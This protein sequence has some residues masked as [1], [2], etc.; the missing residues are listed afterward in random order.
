MYELLIGLLGFVCGI[1]LAYIAE[2]ELKLG[3]IYFSLVKRIIFIIFSASLI[4]YFFSLS[5]YVAIALFLPVSIIMFIA[6]IKIKRKMF[7]I[8]IYLGFI[9][10]AILYADIR[11]VAASLLFLYGLSAG[12][13]WWMRDTVKKKK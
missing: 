5:N 3:K 4:Y 6:E 7:E 11:L 10:P 9:I 13:L 2:E 12:T 8:V 1:S